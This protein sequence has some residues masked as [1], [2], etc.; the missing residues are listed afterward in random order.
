MRAQEACTSCHISC[1]R[2][3]FSLWKDQRMRVPNVNI[4]ILFVGSN[5]PSSSSLK[6]KIRE[7]FSLERRA[8]PA[9]ERSSEGDGPGPPRHTGGH[10]TSLLMVLTGGTSGEG[11]V[12]RLRPSDTE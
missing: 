8:A 1:G 6:C 7:S 10:Y 4:V 5:Q 12:P 9:A 11:H 3:P 2:A